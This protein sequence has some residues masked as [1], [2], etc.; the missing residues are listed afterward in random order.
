MAIENKD[1]R[2]PGQLILALLAERGWSRRSLAIVLAMDETAVNRIVADKRPVDAK[3]ALILE[4]VFHVPAETFLALQKT[5]DLAQARIVAK[6]DPG[7]ATRA[8]LYG[9]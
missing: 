2:S 1:F 7:R 5:L 8:M 6:P 4:E 9:D 3:L